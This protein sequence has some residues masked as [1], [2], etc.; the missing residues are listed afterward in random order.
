MTVKTLPTSGF[1]LSW[2]LPEAKDLVTK[3]LAPSF[4]FVD[5]ETFANTNVGYR[6]AKRGIDAYVSLTAPYMLLAS[7]YGWN[8]SLRVMSGNGNPKALARAVEYLSS[9][10]EASAQAGADAIV[11]CDDICGH[12]APLVDPILVTEAFMPLYEQFVAM[13]QAVGLPAIHH[14]KGDIHEYYTGLAQCGFEGVH[15]AH[16]ALAQTKALFESA[17]EQQLTP[18]GGLVSAYASA[19]SAQELYDFA[20]EL[21]QTS[22][23]MICDDGA[24]GS[25]DEFEN[26]IDVLTKVKA[27]CG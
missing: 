16:P 18:F 2:V 4:V 11:I 24:V 15:I 23:A 19:D 21:A 10:I 27:A 20:I 8:E 7:I 26:I 9:S 6:L 14:S 12:E 5:Y 3:S 13:A 25:K 17:R 22:P 1:G